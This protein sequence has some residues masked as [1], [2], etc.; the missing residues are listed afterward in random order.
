[1]HLYLLGY[2][3]GHSLSPAIHT[4]ALRAAGLPDWR[5]DLLPVP[6]HDLP[7]AVARLRAAACAGGNVTIPHKQAVLPLLDALTPAA[8]A[9]G[10][11]NAVYRQGAHLLGD[12]TDAPGFWADVQRAFGP[13]APGEA[14]VLGAGGAARAV[15]YALTRRGW[16]VTVAARRPEQARGLCESLEAPGGALR[17]AA[18]TRP[19]LEGLRPRLI[20]N[21]TPAGMSPQR[22]GTPW[23]PGT[24]FP[25]GARLYDLVYNPPETRLMRQARAAGLPAVNGLGM[26]VEQAAL[27]FT[28]WT[29]LAA[30]RA[31]MRAAAAAAS[32]TAHARR[33]PA[34]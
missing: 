25:A 31:V 12:N 28:R 10:A 6:P 33:Q 11:V 30:P 3:L 14:L 2:P 1:M 18:L 16:Q 8:R 9:I 5:Y 26:L 19:A 21:A 34:P 17:P 32:D 27:A 24:P 15:V 22:A 13:L 7:A 23:P 29:G 4:A 20:V